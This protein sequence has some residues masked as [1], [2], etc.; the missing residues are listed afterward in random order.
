MAQ[1]PGNHSLAAPSI[2]VEDYDYWHKQ[3]VANNQKYLRLTAAEPRTVATTDF[4]KPEDCSPTK[5]PAITPDFAGHPSWVWTLLGVCLIIF[6]LGLA[7]V[8][9][10]MADIT[11]TQRAVLSWVLALASGCLCAMFP[12]RLLAK[13]EG[14]RAGLAIT[15]TG[16]FG[17]WLISFLL[18]YPN[19]SA[20]QKSKMSNVQPVKVLTEKSATSI[21]P[22]RNELTSDVPPKPSE[23]TAPIKIAEA[24]PTD[25]KIDALN[26]ELSKCTSHAFAIQLL[27]EG[28]HDIEQSI[29]PD[30]SIVTRI[31]MANLLQ[32]LSFQYELGQQYGNALTA[33]ESAWQY[34][35]DDCYSYPMWRD[36]SM[37]SQKV[38]V[39]PLGLG[40]VN[41]RLNSVSLRHAQLNGELDGT[42]RLACQ[43]DISLA[44]LFIGKVTL[45]ETVAARVWFSV[46]LAHWSTGSLEAA[47]TA[48]DKSFNSIGE[49]GVA[50]LEDPARGRIFFDLFLLRAALAAE[51]GQCA[52]AK[53]FLTSAER[54][55]SWHPDQNH[56]LGHLELTIARCLASS[57]E[58][59]VPMDK[60]SAEQVG[61]HQAAIT[62]LNGVLTNAKKRL[63]GS[64]KCEQC[65]YNLVCVLVKLGEAEEDPCNDSLK[66]EAT[67]LFLEV[68]DGLKSLPIEAD[69][70]AIRND[71]FLKTIVTDP[72][73]GKALEEFKWSPPALE[74][75]PPY[76]RQWN[77]GIPYKRVRFLTI[78]GDRRGQTRP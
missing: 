54:F 48:L 12:G 26:S 74:G 53:Q 13:T 40:A 46:C 14:I 19:P 76:P 20:A 16:G 8:A 10:V 18:L 28:I 64:G 49:P 2:S 75:L 3:I 58:K 65:D 38:A 21:A 45:D 55:S 39:P 62:E 68:L 73:V 33:N 1:Q 67:R 42:S 31:K 4:S 72:A 29:P 59:A 78:N 69:V 71:P 60:M 7:G 51:Q 35:K 15:A 37:T 25:V 9:F 5:Q 47:I 50:K 23:H 77:D 27:K 11:D 22:E 17:V 61:A 36:P 44:E 52:K 32:T 70:A 66:R 56:E 57:A 6:A 24:D 30:S 63:S 41:N 34:M 43:K